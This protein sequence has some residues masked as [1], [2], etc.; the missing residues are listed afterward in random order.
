[1]E[2]RELKPSE[3]LKRVN[4]LNKAGFVVTF[5]SSG[6]GMILNVT[7]AKPKSEFSKHNP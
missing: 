1:M 7:K 5:E 3:L 2:N 4:D 6:E